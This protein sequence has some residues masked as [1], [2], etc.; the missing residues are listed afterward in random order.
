MKMH[1]FYVKDFSVLDSTVEDDEMYHQLTKVL[2]YKTGDIIHVFN[3]EVGEWQVSI[4]DIKKKKIVFERIQQIKIESPKDAY[5][6]R[7]ILYMSVIKNSNFDLVVEKAVELGITEVIPVVTERTIKT[8]INIDRLKKIV[9][10]STEQCGRIDM[11]RVGG[12]ALVL[13]DAVAQAKLYADQVFFGHINDASMNHPESAKSC[14][15][16]VGPEGGWSDAE[17]Q[18]FVNENI[19]PISLGQYVLR[20]ETAAIVGCSRIV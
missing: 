6:P 4:K 16:F 8:G 17:I 7:K 14:A 20:A 11:M 3:E 1:R 9:K 19:L 15:L 2:R 18:L 13:H 12:D 10:E 5:R